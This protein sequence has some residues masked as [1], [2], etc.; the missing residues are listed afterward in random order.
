MIER[1]NLKSWEVQSE[2]H[3]LPFGL[4]NTRLQRAVWN[5]VLVLLILIQWWYYPHSK[6]RKGATGGT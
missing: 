2:N 6:R 3:V 5:S 4:K 1:A